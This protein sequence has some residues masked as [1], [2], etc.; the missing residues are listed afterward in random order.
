M[1]TVFQ[2]L[3][4]KKNNILTLFILNLLLLSAGCNSEKEE[5]LTSSVSLIFS[6]EVR[7]GEENLL[8]EKVNAL[9]YLSG[10]EQEGV[11]EREILID[12]HGQGYLGH[13]PQGKWHIS[14]WN[15]LSERQ[16]YFDK[17]DNSINV[18]RSGNYLQEPA[19]FY[20]G[21]SNFNHIQD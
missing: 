17:S 10:K 5:D 1:S 11:M 7:N 18:L 15:T 12:T 3:M 13:L 16:L 21:V 14:Y 4:I 6:A 9:L 2:H 8:L 20:A 19:P